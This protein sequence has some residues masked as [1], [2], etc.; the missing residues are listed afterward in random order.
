MFQTVELGQKVGKGEYKT[1]ELLLRQQL[2]DLQQQL[3]ANR[4]FPVII[5]FAGVSGAGKSTSTNLLNKW[6]DARWINTQGYA[7]P[8]GFEKERPEFWR[9]WRDLPPRGQIGIYLSGRYSR[10]LLDYVYDRIPQETFMQKLEHINHFEK[11]LADERIALMF[12][13]LV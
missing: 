2:L 8:A 12:L 6:M 13:T 11:A 5:D 1:R 10:P 9:F 7:E 3:R 4:G